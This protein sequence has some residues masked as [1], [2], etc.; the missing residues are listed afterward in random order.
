[1]LALRSSRCN[2]ALNFIQELPRFLILLLAMQWFENRHLGLNSHVDPD[3]S[4][5][6]GPSSN[7]PTT[8]HIDDPV[9]AK[10]DITLNWSSGE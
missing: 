3:F 7:S 8:V 6:P 10:V 4:Q 9:K 2:P 5:L 1:M